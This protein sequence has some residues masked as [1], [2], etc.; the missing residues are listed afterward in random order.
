MTDEK[1][2]C[3]NGKEEPPCRGC[4]EYELTYWCETCGRAVGE[5]RC[6]LCGLKARKM[7]FDKEG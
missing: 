1:C 2:N 4:L 5:K 6:P 3:R 7:K